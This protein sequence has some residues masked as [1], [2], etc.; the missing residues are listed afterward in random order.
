MLSWDNSISVYHIAEKDQVRVEGGAGVK[1][2]FGSQPLNSTI[3]PVQK[4]SS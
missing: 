3:Q 4:N 1:D 2:D